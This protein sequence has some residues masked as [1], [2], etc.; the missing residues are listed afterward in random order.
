MHHPLPVASSLSFPSDPPLGRETVEIFK[1]E[2]EGSLPENDERATPSQPQ[3]PGT[4][5]G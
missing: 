3:Q 5:Y 4:D 2:S 1:F